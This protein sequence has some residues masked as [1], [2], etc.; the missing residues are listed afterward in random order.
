[1][2]EKRNS[3]LSTVYVS[4]KKRVGHTYFGDTQDTC[5]NADIKIS[6]TLGPAFDV[7]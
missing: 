1:M 7:I 6:R 2:L 5:I 4:Q 3:E